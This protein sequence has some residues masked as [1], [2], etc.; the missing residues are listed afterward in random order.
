MFDAIE[1]G[2]STLGLSG[3]AVASDSASATD[4]KRSADTSAL[5]SRS[6]IAFAGSA[7]AAANTAEATID[8]MTFIVLTAIILFFPVPLDYRRSSVID[9]MA[10]P[11]PTAQS[12]HSLI[13]FRRWSF[14]IPYPSYQA[15]RPP[16]AQPVTMPCRTGVPYAGRWC[17]RTV[18]SGA[19][20]AAWPPRIRQA[21]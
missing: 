19:C 11:A 2:N 13:R 15:Y 17:R 4:C 3:I 6:C 7:Q 10:F 8:T 12:P 16:I 21:R 20:R 5:V 9:T 1:S 18:W 14:L